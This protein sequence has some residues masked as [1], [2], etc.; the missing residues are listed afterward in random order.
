MSFLSKQVRLRKSKDEI[1]PTEVIESSIGQDS[2][3]DIF[4]RIAARLAWLFAFPVVIYEFLRKHDTIRK[5]LLAWALGLPLIHLLFP[6]NGIATVL[7]VLGFALQFVYAILFMVIQFG[8]LFWFMGRT[9][10]TEVHPGDPQ[11]ITWD[12]Y[13]GQKN[14]VERVKQWNILLRDREVFARMGGQALN[15]LLLVGPPGTGKTMMAKAL[16][17]SGGVAFLG[18]EGSTFRGMFWGMDTMKV[19]GFVGKARKLAQRYG[20][21]I[22]YIDEIDAVA[23]SRGNVQTGAAGGGQMQG[24]GAMGMMGS[25]A[26]TRLLY[27]MDG[28][29][30]LGMWSEALN[31]TRA[32]F[33]LE[34]LDRGKVMFM[35]ATNRPDVLDPAV[36]RPGRFDQIINVDEPDEEGRREII[37]GYLGKVKSDPDIDVDSLVL[38]TPRATPAHI[39]SVITKDAPREAIFN[40]RD[41]VIQEDI[42]LGFQE[43]L[44]G[45]ANPI[46]NWEP[47]QKRSVAAH[48]AGHAIAKMRWRETE[49]MVR[50]SIVRRGRALGYVLAV[51]P[52]D[53][54]THPQSEWIEDVYV[55]LAGDIGAAIIMGERWTG[56]G[57]DFL[58]VRERVFQIFTHG[59][60]GSFPVLSAPGADPGKDINDAV[61]RFMDTSVEQVDKYLRSQKVPLEALTDALVERE[62]MSG[63]EAIKVIEAAGGIGD[64]QI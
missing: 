22:A 64:G 6:S 39:M 41:Y 15:G 49:R 62:D 53:V 12:D 59:G 45:I 42:E 36:L 50:V 43:K 47:K 4:E 9:R 51:S 13:W 19:M 11:Q 56:M 34:I 29:E 7:L 24:A 17:G 18:V 44:I 1:D 10:S 8:S 63:E 21:C 32:W 3:P 46:A 30:L 28:I 40:G 23:A 52:F 33:N 14:L 58:K 26:L 60:F 38:D 61:N 57:G 25:G 20:A 5:I 37:L 55:S 2:G 16:A 35:G 27:E 48:E 54:Y 31:R